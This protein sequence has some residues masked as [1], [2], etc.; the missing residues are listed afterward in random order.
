MPTLIG[1]AGQECRDGSAE[2]PFVGA[3]APQVMLMKLAKICNL[4]ALR[5]ELAGLRRLAS[6]IWLFA[7]AFSRRC[8][9]LRRGQR[10]TGV[11]H[12]CLVLLIA[13]CYVTS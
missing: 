2:N 11:L 5:L 9:A 3:I 12:E 13:C 10:Y 4:F 6:F 7:L 1:T 8:R